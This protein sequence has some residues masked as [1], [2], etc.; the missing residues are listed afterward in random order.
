M[1]EGRRW[2]VAA[3]GGLRGLDEESTTAAKDAGRAIGAELA[4]AGFGLVV[5][6]SSDESLE[7]MWSRDMLLR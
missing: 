2:H 1:A 6:F 3:I 7:P 5:Y 4:T